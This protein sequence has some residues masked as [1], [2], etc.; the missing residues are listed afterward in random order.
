MFLNLVSNYD[1][2]AAKP[3]S[4]AT[5]KM[6]GGVSKVLKG[7]QPNTPITPGMPGGF[8]FPKVEIRPDPG[9]E[10]IRNRQKEAE[11]QKR[12]LLAA[13][14]YISKT[15]AGP[16]TVVMEEL[17]RVESESLRSII[18]YLIQR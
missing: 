9:Q 4:G 7:S 3:E 1:L 18:H 2:N 13:Y 10:I 5:F 16:K 14:D 6:S 8:G 12:R 15:G 11:E 17:R